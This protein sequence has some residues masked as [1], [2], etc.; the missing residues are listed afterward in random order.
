MCVMFVLQTHD[1]NYNHLVSE[2]VRFATRI[3]TVYQN[4]VDT[5]KY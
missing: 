5:M 4:A 1:V 3:E 2:N